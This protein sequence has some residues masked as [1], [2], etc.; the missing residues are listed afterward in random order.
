MKKLIAL[1][2]SL[3]MVILIFASC[4]AN[5]EEL[6]SEP[7]S[8]VPSVEV[9]SKEENSEASSEIKSE[10]SSEIV[11]NEPEDYNFVP[12]VLF[13]E[14][15]W[16]TIEL[17]EEW[18][19][20]ALEDTQIHKWFF[21]LVEIKHPHNIAAQMAINYYVHH[22]FENPSMIGGEVEYATKDVAVKMGEIFANV[23]EDWVFTYRLTEEDWEIN[24]NN[25]YYKAMAMFGMGG[26]E[27]RNPKVISAQKNK[28]G[29]LK[30]AIAWI[31]PADALLEG[32]DDQ[33][34]DYYYVQEDGTWKIA[35][36][37]ETK[38]A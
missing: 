20:K 4:D 13:D 6:S 30:I 33:Q 2:M 29:V 14:D 28:D 24:A 5:R 12:E 37:I 23:S 1:M 11:S 34:F 32:F 35:K 16:E 10:P 27:L 15:P 22:T 7:V 3:S 26:I 8:E 17:T 38:E 18:Q 9:S 25:N 31:K 19:E 36:I 21:H